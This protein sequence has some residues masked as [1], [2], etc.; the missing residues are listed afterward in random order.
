[1]AK[2]ARKSGIKTYEGAAENL[3]FEDCA[4]D[5]V[6]M[7][8]VICF[9]DDVLKAFS[10]AFRVLRK[11][12]FL[13]VSFIDRNSKIGR[14]YQEEKDKNKFYKDAVFHSA[15]EVIKLLE[16]ADFKIQKIN[17]TVFD[18]DNMQ[19]ERFEEGYGR[20]CFVSIKAF[21]PEN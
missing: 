16:K 3:P 14:H 1:M 17:Q 19:I 21:K 20:G 13:I 9:L 2:I 18:P 10:E 12:G 11:G 5:F 15:D 8:T 6:L 4:F 7:V